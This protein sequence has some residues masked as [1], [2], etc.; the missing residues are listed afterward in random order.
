MSRSPQTYGWEDFKPREDEDGNPTGRQL[1]S[2][3]GEIRLGARRRSAGEFEDWVFLALH[4]REG[5]WTRLCLD[6]RGTLIAQ[7]FG[8]TRKE[9]TKQMGQ[10]LK[11]RGLAAYRS[12]DSDEEDWR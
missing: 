8:K 9:A 4:T 1:M 5:I 3:D 2:Y 10:S 12:L 7:G 6:A 11:A